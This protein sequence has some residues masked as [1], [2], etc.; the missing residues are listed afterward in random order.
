MHDFKTPS[1][2]A[3]KALCAFDLCG[4]ADEMAHRRDVPRDG[5]VALLFSGVCSKGCARVPPKKN[6]LLLWLAVPPSR[7]GISG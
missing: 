3:D 6:L 2:F 1:K 7:S 4:V 5:R